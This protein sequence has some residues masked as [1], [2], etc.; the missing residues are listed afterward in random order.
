MNDTSNIIRIMNNLP[1]SEVLYMRLEDGYP[2][3]QAV[4]KE[5][6]MYRI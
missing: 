5:K 6:G 1:D 4:F 2:T 3:I